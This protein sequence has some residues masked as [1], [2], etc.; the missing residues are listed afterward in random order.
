MFFHEL[1]EDV[2]LVV[3]NSSKKPETAGS[4]AARC[5]AGING[6]K[7]A[8]VARYYNLHNR[9]RTGYQDLISLNQTGLRAKR[10][11]ITLSQEATQ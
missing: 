4:I 3:K 11:L 8:F 1:P 10:K 6:Q 9:E 2:Q 7:V 5:G